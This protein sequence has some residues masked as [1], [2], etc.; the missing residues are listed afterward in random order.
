MRKLF[1]FSFFIFSFSI[2][3]ALPWTNVTAG[4]RTSGQYDTAIVKS[5]STKTK[6]YRIYKNYGCPPYN[7]CLHDYDEALKKAKL[8]NKPI[9]LYFTGNTCVN[10]RKMETN[11]WPDTSI[12]KRIKNNYIFVSL[13]VDDQT[14]LPK[15]KVT[16]SKT[17][18]YKIET[19]GDKWIELEVSVF[20]NN[21]QPFYVVSN[22]NG[23]VLTQGGYT[24]TIEE[25]KKFLDAGK[26][27]F[28]ASS[29]VA[30]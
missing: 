3:S 17:G 1:F 9:L 16:T 21:T 12:Y 11:I 4:S 2:L 8:D 7:D 5:D 27:A 14:K 26:I 24:S 19:V 25:F 22:S 15:D 6:V 18:N 23:T 29:A 30:K 10:C 20:K 28:N 13:Y